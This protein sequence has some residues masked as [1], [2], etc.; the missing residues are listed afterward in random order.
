MNLNKQAKQ[1]YSELYAMPPSP[2][3]LV[4]FAELILNEFV[5]KLEEN[6]GAVAWNYGCDSVLFINRNIDGRK[7]LQEIKK[8]FIDVISDKSTE[9][10]TN[11]E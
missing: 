9:A 1:F 2:V 3:D 6:A 7:S 8:E 10:N 4:N 5:A 11:G